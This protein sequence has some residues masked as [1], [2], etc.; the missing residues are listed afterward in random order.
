VRVVTGLSEIETRDLGLPD[1][2]LAIVARNLPDVPTFLA[3][4]ESALTAMPLTLNTKIRV[5]S[6][7]VGTLFGSSQYVPSKVLESYRPRLREIATV[8]IE[9]FQEK[10]NETTAI[11]LSVSTDLLVNSLASTTPDDWHRPNP[12]QEDDYQKAVQ[13][14]L[15]RTLESSCKTPVWRSAQV[16]TCELPAHASLPA[17]AF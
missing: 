17:W 5:M 2:D 13:T 9:A 16:L 11:R 4:V 1:F 3:S 14:S 15:K 7:Q 10:S 8:R 12:S 6:P